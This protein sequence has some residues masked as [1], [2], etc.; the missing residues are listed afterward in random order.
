MIILLR[1]KVVCATI[2]TFSMFSDQPLFLCPYSP[3]P[4][5]TCCVKYVFYY[6]PSWHWK[7]IEADIVIFKKNN[8]LL[9]PQVW[10]LWSSWYFSTFEF[11]LGKIHIKWIFQCTLCYLSKIERHVCLEVKVINYFGLYLV[12]VLGI[13]TVDDWFVLVL[14]TWSQKRWPL[15]IFLTN[16][17][18]LARCFD[19]VKEKQ[20][21]WAQYSV[22]TK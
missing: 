22:P 5:E 15:E 9:L 14:C 11:F 16:D 13:R 17:I 19:F 8:W 12:F 2:Y 18:L 20:V 7:A 6:H 1:Q 21:T 10:F 4:F 3:A